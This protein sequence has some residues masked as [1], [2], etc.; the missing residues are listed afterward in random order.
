MIQLPSDL[1]RQL[2]TLR[3]RGYT[4]SGYI[5]TLLEREMKNIAIKEGV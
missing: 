3:A 2:D 1:K 5:R 4:V